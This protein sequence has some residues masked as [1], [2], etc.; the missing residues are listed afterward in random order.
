MSGKN[1]RE[2]HFGRRY[3]IKTT[4]L[5]G[6]AATL[7]GAGLRGQETESP[8][9]K[10]LKG[11]SLLFLSD[12]PEAYEQLIESIK[13]IPDTNLLVTTLKVDFQKP[14]EIIDAFC[15]LSADILLLCISRF[16]FNFGSLGDDLDALN[17]PIIVFSS[18]KD[19]LL[20]DA[21]LAASLR[22]NEAPVRLAVSQSQALELVKIAASPGILEDKSALLFGRPFDSTSVP[23]RS[24]SKERVFNSTGVRVRYRPIEELATLLEDVDERSASSEMERWKSEA[25]EVVQV[26]DETILDSC[27]LYVL[28]RSIVDGEG[29]SAIGIDCL[30]FTLGPKPTLPYPCLAFSRLRDEGI[31]AVC[32]ADVHAMLSM[33]FLQ[34]ICRKSSFMCNVNSLNVEESIVTLSHCAAPLRLRGANAA[35]MRYRLHDYHGFKR[36]VVPEVEFPV[37]AEVVAAS[38]TKDMKSFLLWP[39]RIE[40]QVKDTARS[41]SKTDFTLDV[42]A[43][44]MDVKIRD[45]DRF[46]QSIPGAHMIMVLGSHTQAIEDALFGMNVSIVGPSDFTPPEV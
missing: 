28:L 42:C 7:P 8:S 29:L 44:T 45:A 6:M 1:H 2:I 12:S 15:C 14:Q 27:K 43:N 4:A 38:F 26:P 37:G 33:M 3:F 20:I 25:L 24:L 31:S 41:A 35:P 22:A 18:N 30:G 46:L 36:G 39:G 10:Q 19:V 17:I 34:E 32:E 23:A 21:N 5:A 16:V 40:T 11:K 13:T 9:E